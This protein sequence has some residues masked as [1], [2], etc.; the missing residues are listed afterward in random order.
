MRHG[1]AVV[2]IREARWI[3]AHPNDP[4]LQSE[5]VYTYAIRSSGSEHVLVASRIAEIF[6]RAGYRISAI[7]NHPTRAQYF[8]EAYSRKDHLRLH[9]LVG[10]ELERASYASYAGYSGE[11]VYVSA[12]RLSE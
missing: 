1:L 6:T 4:S 5:W 7:G 10:Y 8:F 9:V 11:A 12:E 2:A 3:D